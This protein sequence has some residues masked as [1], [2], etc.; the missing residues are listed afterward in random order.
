MNNLSLYELG[1]KAKNGDTIAMMNII[2]RKKTLIKKYAYG[3]EDAYQYIILKLIEGI[4][5]YKF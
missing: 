3:D 4:K 2:E 1:I 5:N